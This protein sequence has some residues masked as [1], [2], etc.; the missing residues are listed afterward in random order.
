MANGADP[1]SECYRTESPARISDF[2]RRWDEYLPLDATLCVDKLL[3]EVLA[4]CESRYGVVPV[5]V[6]RD[7]EIVSRVL[8]IY[9]AVVQRGWTSDVEMFKSEA[10][11]VD[12]RERVAL[13][14]RNRRRI[15]QFLEASLRTHGDL[16][17]SIA[18]PPRDPGDHEGLQDFERT[19]AT[20]AESTLDARIYD[21][22]WNSYASGELRNA[23]LAE[24]APE[25]TVEEICSASLGFKLGEQLQAEDTFFREGDGGGG[26]G[27]IPL[28]SAFEVLA[29]LCERHPEVA[30]KYSNELRILVRKHTLHFERANGIKYR[31]TL[32]YVVRVRALDILQAVA[33]PEDRVLVESLLLD[34]PR[35]APARS[36]YE[37]P[38]GE[39][40]QIRGAKILDAINAKAEAHKPSS[41]DAKE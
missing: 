11:T 26:G 35:S 21:E 4:Q 1:F 41:E 14:D 36:K 34:P 31:E 3:P 8:N 6:V 22:V 20:A 28:T 13:L 38:L 18:M 29:M 9:L 37:P 24:V 33:L 39:D 40:I 12:N 27:G 16:R 19:L 23:Y 32:D 25:K 30:E 10:P 5:L 7:P 17:E 15:V 2:I